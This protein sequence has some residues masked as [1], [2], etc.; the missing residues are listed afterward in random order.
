M[1]RRRLL[2]TYSNADGPIRTRGTGLLRYR[3]RDFVTGSYVFMG[4]T[5][6]DDVV[7]GGV[8]VRF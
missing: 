5:E 6:P 4:A 8:R 3:G 2:Q 1:F 7:N